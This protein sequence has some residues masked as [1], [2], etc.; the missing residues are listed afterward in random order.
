MKKQLFDASEMAKAINKITDEITAAFP[1]DKED[2]VLVGIHHLGVPLAA[3]LKDEIARRTGRVL[4]MGKLDISMYRDDI[5]DRTKRLPVIE[6]TSIPFD[7]NNASIIL[8][9]DVLSSGRTIRAALDA[10]VDYGRAGLIRLAVL[11]DRGDSE[12]PIKADF[13][14]FN[15]NIPADRRVTVSFGGTPAEPEEPGVYET[16]WRGPETKGR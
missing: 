3:R 11:V 4:A 15:V 5:G 1:A 13:T 6:E 12:F 8:V 9:D 2:P 16:D 10:L 7:V 14:G